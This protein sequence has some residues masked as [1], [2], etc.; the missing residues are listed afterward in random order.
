MQG[1]WWHRGCPN[2]PKESYSYLLSSS[3]AWEIPKTE[4]GTSPKIVTLTVQPLLTE[5]TVNQHCASRS[6]NL[7]ISSTESVL[8]QRR[9][10][11]SFKNKT[12]LNN[13]SKY[14]LVTTVGLLFYKILFVYLTQFF[15][16]NSSLQNLLIKKIVLYLWYFGK[17]HTHIYALFLFHKIVW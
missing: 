14:P 16:L 12:L 15:F 6:R 8:A 4:S 13:T 9:R 7:S 1:D 17:P 11:L 10:K 2:K 5:Q 3:R